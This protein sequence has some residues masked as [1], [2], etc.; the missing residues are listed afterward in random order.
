MDTIYL[1][2]RNTMTKR[3]I[4]SAGA[5]PL[6]NAILHDHKYTLEI[7]GQIG[8]DAKTG[9][10]AQGIEDQTAQTLEAIKKIL[11]TVGWDLTHVVKA[12]VYLSDM[13]N[14]TKMNEAYGK[15]FKAD[16]PARAAFAVKELPR[17]ALVE[18]ECTAAGDKAN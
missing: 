5:F 18:I 11:G 10:L 1:Q 15:Y 9:E 8:I 3:I 2:G 17:G 12:R 14:Y 7:S 4:K 13:K 16:Y 6:S